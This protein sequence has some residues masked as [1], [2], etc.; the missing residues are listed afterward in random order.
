[1]LWVGWFGKIMKDDI[2]ISKAEGQ[3]EI[4]TIQGS[5]ITYSVSVFSNVLK[6]TRNYTNIVRKYEKI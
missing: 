6:I 3:C 2:I 5:N 4:H 1:M